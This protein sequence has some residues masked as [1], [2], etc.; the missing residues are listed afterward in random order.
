MD[1]RA[2]FP[3]STEN[4]SLTSINLPQVKHIDNNFLSQNENVYEISLP[5]VTKVGDNFLSANTNLTEIDFPNLRFIGE[6]FLMANNKLTK[7]NLPK[8]K[9]KAVLYYKIKNLKANV[10]DRRENQL[11]NE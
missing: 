2:P 4:N 10:D 7:I 11:L 5:Q 3:D 9:S 8:I 1:E 6:K